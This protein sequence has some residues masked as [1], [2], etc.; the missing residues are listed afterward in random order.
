MTVCL[1]VLHLMAVLLLSRYPERRGM[2]L[3]FNTLPRYLRGVCRVLGVAPEQLA[4]IIGRLT[5]LRIQ[6]IPNCDQ[7]SG[8]PQVHL[9]SMEKVTDIAQGLLP[10]IEASP[11]TQALAALIG[12]RPAAAYTAKC[13]SLELFDPVL[14]LAACRAARR[15]PEVVVWDPR[16]P[17]E[18]LRDIQRYLGQGDFTFFPWPGWYRRLLGLWDR[19]KLLLQ[20]PATTLCSLVL[21]G[22]AWQDARKPEFKVITEFYD[23][24]RL[25]GTA[26]DA[27]YWIDGDRIRKDDVLFFLSHHQSELLQKDGYQPA[28]IVELFHQK[29]YHL[30]VLSDLPYALDTL[31]TLASHYRKAAAVALGSGEAFL[32]RVYGRAW[33]DYLEFAPLFAACR[34]R[35]L[36]Y[37]TFPNGH[38]G[39]RFDDAVVTGLCRQHGIR[40]VG[41]Q[42]RS[43]YSRNYEYFF[44]CFDL[45]LSWGP[46][47]RENLPGRLQFVERA[48][49]V[50]CIYLDH[51]LSTLGRW[52]QQ[53][54][55][56]ERILVAIFDSNIAYDHHYSKDY[57]ISFLKSCA[58]LARRYPD[59]HFL[60]K[61]KE[62]QD[63]AIVMEDGEFHRLWEEVR[64]NF[65]FAGRQRYDYAEIMAQADIVIALAFTTPGVEGLV[66]GKPA[67]YYSELQ[68]GGQ[69]FS[70]SGDLVAHDSGELEQWFA[71]AREQVKQGYTPNAPVLDGL[72]AFRDGRARSRIIGI[73]EG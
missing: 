2:V 31:K 50:G 69:P 5:G 67:L 41:C 47:W 55:A 33:Q 16:W 42:T 68:C 38:A 39:L 54:P 27:D 34:G 6:K 66:L 43:L 48:E 51:L 44:D 60:V 24:T 25:Q 20:L 64:G 22:V 14:S 73:L 56:Q 7:I 1:P 37:L 18:W 23:P 4:G 19:L 9:S 30:Q 70:G 11:W 32:S 71:R 10:R 15:A 62:P 28:E 35:N 72:S 12:V 52:Q 13:L 29:G 17:Q 63:A 53:L 26:Y 36:I 65:E 46:A 8:Y 58:V 3:Y 21:Q 40:S 57:V 59:C 45:Y 49:D 61:N